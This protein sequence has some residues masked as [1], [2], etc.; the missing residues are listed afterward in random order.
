MKISVL[1][2][3]APISWDQAGDTVTGGI[4]AELRSAR[5]LLGGDRQACQAPGNNSPKSHG[6]HPPPPAPEAQGSGVSTPGRAS[7]TWSRE[8][9]K[10]PRPG[11]P[12]IKAG[13]CERGLPVE[14]GPGPRAPRGR[15]KGPAVGGPSRLPLLWGRGMPGSFERFGLFPAFLSHLCSV[16]HMHAHT[17]GAQ[18]PGAKRPVGGLAWG[19]AG[20]RVGAWPPGGETGTL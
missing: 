4:L 12:Q 20:V 18:P 13:S 17:Q 19:R 1:H 7:H 16:S 3:S 2:T 15:G 5:T 8:G 6:T 14:L 10:P 11:Q 9:D